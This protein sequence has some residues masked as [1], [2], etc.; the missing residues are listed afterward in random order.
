MRCKA[1]DL[2]ERFSLLADGREEATSRAR[3]SSLAAVFRTRE[4]AME[5][6]QLPLK[7]GMIQKR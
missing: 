5:R 3:L 7:F 6:S 1:L 4:R 2:E